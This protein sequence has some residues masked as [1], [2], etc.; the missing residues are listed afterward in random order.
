MSGSGCQKNLFI[1]ADAYIG[2]FVNAANSQYNAID[3]PAGAM[4]AP[5][6]MNSMFGHF[7]YA[8]APP[9]LGCPCKIRQQTKSPPNVGP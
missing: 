8:E 3:F 7:R 6:P 5:P 9:G 2:P 4:W 1:G